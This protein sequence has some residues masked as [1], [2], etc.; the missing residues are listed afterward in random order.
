MYSVHT[1]THVC[2]RAPMKAAA[3]NAVATQDTS[4]VPP[5]NPLHHSRDARFTAS[6]STAFGRTWSSCF[7]I[8]ER[9]V[10]SRLLFDTSAPSCSLHTGNSTGNHTV[11]N[12]SPNQ[13]YTCCYEAAKAHVSHSLTSRRWNSQLKRDPPSAKLLYEGRRMLMHASICA[14]CPG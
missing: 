6:A 3:T 7:N 8:N 11:I 12:Q 13:C 1:H 5:L 2:L 9:V 10:G 14:A 4:H